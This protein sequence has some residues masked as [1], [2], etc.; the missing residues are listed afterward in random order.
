[1][2][3]ISYA[4]A[5]VDKNYGPIL[6]LRAPGILS[7]SLSLLFAT[8]WVKDSRGHTA[9]AAVPPIGSLELLPTGCAGQEEI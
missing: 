1:M 7:L 4:L 3:I 8:G 5:L 2:A 6:S 9:S